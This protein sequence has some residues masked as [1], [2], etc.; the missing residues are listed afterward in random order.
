MRRGALLRHLAFRDRVCTTMRN[1]LH[2]QRFVEVETPML[3]RSTP[4]GARDYIVPSRVNPGKFYALPQSPQLFKQLMMVGGLDRY[5]QIVR[6]FRD[7]DLRADRQPEFTQLDVEMSFVTEDDVI[8]MTEGLMAAIFR[9]NL[10]IEIPTPFPRVSYDEAIA[11]YGV[12]KP[13]LRFG[14]ELVDIGDL[15]AQAEF[16]VFK[17]VVDAKGEVK[18]ICVPGAGEMSR[19]DID[20]LTEKVK[21]TGAKGLA[22]FKVTDGALSSQIAKFFDAPLQRKIV[23]RFKAANGDLLL[24]VADTP[25]QVAQSLNFLRLHLAGQ[26][27][28]IPKDVYKLGWVVNFPLVEWNEEEKRFDAM[29][30]PFTS[31]LPEDLDKLESDPAAVRSRA[32]DIILNGVELGGGSIRIHKTEI[33]QR[34]FQMLGIGPDQAEEK[35]GFLLKA[36]KHGA[37]PHGGIAFGLDRLCRLLL[38]LDTI[39][40]VIAFPKT[41]KAFCPLTQAPSDVDERQLRELGI[42][43]RREQK[44]DA[45]D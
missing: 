12:D 24:F 38:G 36:L 9:E 37:P 23:E 31:I 27:G 40:D 10:G 34:V 45:S 5:F 43:L 13:D 39:R 44:K 11:R 41:Q 20:G 6:C 42:A 17:Q 21:E 33:Q 3:T 15:A 28:M 8:A 25:K 35:F 19:A 1:Y 18:G 29:H 16:R 26:R 32:Y 22:W 14:M 4:E 30:H 2:G 7:E